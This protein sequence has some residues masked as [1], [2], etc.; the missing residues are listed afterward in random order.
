MNEEFKEYLLKWLEGLYDEIDFWRDYME[1]EEWKKSP[2][3]SKTV[4][5]N[6]RFEL[7]DD[8][9]LK[10]E[11]RNYYFADIGS[12]PFS[13]CG[14]ITDKVNLH[15]ISID[16][17]AYP[18]K[19]LKKKNN[20]DNKIR[21]QTGFVELLDYYFEENS[22]D[23]VHMSNSLDHCFDAVFGIWQLLYICKI[24]GQ[25]ILRHA[26]NEAENADY[27]GLHQWN[28]SLHNLENSFVIWR[29]D[30]RIDVCKTFAD[31]ADIKL[32]PDVKEKGGKWI[33]NKV[34]MIKKKNVIIP[35]NNY[36]KEMF[37]IVYDFFTKTILEDVW[38]KR[39][40]EKEIQR[41]LVRDAICRLG[42]N[43]DEAKKLIEKYQLQS[44]IIYGYGVIGK[45]LLELMQKIDI[46]VSYIVDRKNI[47]Y[48]GR[49]TVRL[50]QLDLSDDKIEKIIVTV[51]YDYEKIA[52]KLIDF[53]VERE[54]ILCVKKMFAEFLV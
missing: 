29:E 36:Q 16:P 43:L 34:V 53:G 30:R 9:P 19:I 13:R 20:F 1:G 33:H 12:G 17:L 35:D 5:P 7:E 52:Q 37:A 38:I 50:E 24:G 31:Y 27:N 44:V 49:T 39:G 15:A 25:V 4:S 42:T 51:P 11:G 14:V 21:L 8:L 26:E 28:L 45:A 32:Y 40:N 6:R 47:D 48:N 10:Y 46:T 3:F 22:F 2:N 41:K 18:Y 54:R 23:M